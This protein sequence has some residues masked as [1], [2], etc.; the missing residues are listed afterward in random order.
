MNRP[1][2]RKLIFFALTWGAL[3][4]HEYFLKGAFYLER[5]C[6]RLV[7]FSRLLVHRL[8]LN[9]FYFAH[10]GSNKQGVPSSLVRILYAFTLGCCSSAVV[11]P[12]G[13]FS[14]NFALYFEG[15]SPNK[16]PLRV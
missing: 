14:L 8:L 6:T 7:R 16:A 1:L 12:T 2:D 15:A 10:N 3:W 11:N 5:F 4:P 13:K 9:N